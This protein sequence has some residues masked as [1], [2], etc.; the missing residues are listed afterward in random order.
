MLNNYK[1]MGTVFRKLILVPLFLFFGL[2]SA[3][4]I[5]QSSTASQEPIKKVTL[6]LK[7]KHQ[8]Q[9]AGYYAA[10]EKGFYKDLGIDVTLVEASEDFEPAEAVFDGNAEFGIATSDIIILRS[11]GKD[12]V[13]LASIFQ[14]SPQI[15]IA[16]K[17]SGIENTQG[18]FGKRVALEPHTADIITYMRDEGVSLNEINRFSHSYGI[19][20]LINGEVDAMTAYKS[21]EPF[22]L[23]QTGFDYIIIDPSMGGID[24][25]GDILF[26]TEELIKQDPVLVENFRKASLKGWEYALKN[27]GEIIDLIY[28]KYTQRHT[29][30][31]LEFEARRMQLLIMPDVVEIGYSNPER[32]KRILEIYGEQNMLQ[33]K[34]SIDGLFYSDYVEDEAPFPWKLIT[35]LSTL[36]ILI[37]SVSIFYYNTSRRLKTESSKRLLVQQELMQSETKLKE[38]NATKDKFYSIIAHDL[39]NPLSAILGFTELI[40]MDEKNENKKENR[41]FLKIIKETIL[42]TATLLN[43]LLTWSRSQ[44]GDIEFRPEIY[45]LTQFIEDNIAFVKGPATQKHITI[46]SHIT[47]EC[48]IFG[49]ANMINTIIRNLLSNAIK[50][51]SDFGEVNIKAIMTPTFCEISIT[52]NGIGISPVDQSNLFDTNTKF[53]SEGTNAEKGTGLGLLLSK[54]FIEKHG[55][56]IW[57]ESEVDKGSTFTFTLPRFNNF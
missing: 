12:A 50:F 38:A 11:Q 34:L 56:T 26:T 32:W 1:I 6:Q 36:I 9:F 41:E 33:S 46:H 37:A 23:T 10:I 4:L 44:L 53:T 49:D 22:L 51:T 39:R 24:F 42:H 2:V 54:E 57:L 27:S 3:N 18:L 7:W 35:A 29:K 5:A 15:L 19:E 13:L 28:S 14:H 52:D 31:H 21:D 25:Y 55:G 48:T 17:S 8:F 40:L 43:N 45:R 47:P 30:E 20:Q 16:A